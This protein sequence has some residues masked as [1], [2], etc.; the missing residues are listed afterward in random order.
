MCGIVGGGHSGNWAEPCPPPPAPA[1]LKK[2]GG[3]SILEDLASG[4]KS[5]G[6]LEMKVVGSLLLP[7]LDDTLMFSKGLGK[8]QLLVVGVLF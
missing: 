7:V 8:L 5:Q 1:C 2:W 3:G 6:E 4:S